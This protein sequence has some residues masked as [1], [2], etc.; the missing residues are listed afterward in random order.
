[1]KLC[2]NA[3]W[4]YVRWGACQ[5]C[6]D[7][8]SPGDEQLDKE[9]CIFANWSAYMYSAH[10]I[11]ITPDNVPLSVTKGIW[12]G[13]VV[14]SAPKWCLRQDLQEGKER[15]KHHLRLLLSLTLPG[16]VAVMLLLMRVC[17]QTQ[18]SCNKPFSCHPWT[19]GSV[20]PWAQSGRD[21]DYAKVTRAS[22]SL[23]RS[24]RS[25]GALR[26]TTTPAHGL[27]WFVLGT[28]PVLLHWAGFYTLRL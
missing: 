17:L 20:L 7:A 26:Q 24:L 23:R 27:L 28:N 15:P 11:N 1:M 14:S 2:T 25:L 21:R 3:L 13:F 18:W 8:S 6:S 5:P 19:W 12:R 4:I 16:S 10:K 22:K 9:P